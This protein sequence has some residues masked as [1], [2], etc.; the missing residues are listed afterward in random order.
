MPVPPDRDPP[1]PAAPGIEARTRDASRRSTRSTPRRATRRSSSTCAS[2][3]RRRRDSTCRSGRGG[4]RGPGDPSRASAVSTRRSGAAGMPQRFLERLAPGGQLLA[5]DADPDR[6]AEDRGAAAAARLRRRPAARPAHELR[7]P[8]RGAR[9]GRL[10]RR[11]SISSSPTS[12]CRRCRSTIPR[13]GFSFKLDGP[14]DMRM[15]PT[16]GLSAAQWLARATRR[17]ACRGAGRERRR[18]ARGG[19]RRR[20]RRAARR[21]HDDPR[22]ARESCARRSA[23]ACPTR[24]SSSAVRRV[25][26][27]DPDRGQR[28]VRRAR[29][30]AAAIAGLPAP[31]R[32][33]GVPDV[34]FGRGPARQEGA[35]RRDAARVSMRRLGGIIRASPAE[36]RR[37]P[38][39]AAA[40]LRWARVASDAVKE[41]G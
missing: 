11:A 17:R 36:R 34:P 13:R 14:L 23:A 27:A 9:R 20:A 7:G 4:A 5:L 10:A 26:Q 6:A 29:R 37:N 22:A 16:R 28:R 8:A 33:R 39:A 31:R 24:T 40:K 38:R 2:R 12:A 25:F 19:N 35:S 30:A 1:T 21:D 41:T 18:A 32:P 15:N 3:G